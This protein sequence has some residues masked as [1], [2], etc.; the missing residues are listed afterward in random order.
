M[1][2]PKGCCYPDCFV[3]PLDDCYYDDDELRITEIE[4]L[5][6]LLANLKASKKKGERLKDNPLYRKA[7]NRRDY[8]LNYEE[9]IDYQNRYRTR[10]NHEEG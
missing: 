1:S 8:L 9:R 3:C 2:K 10:K 4:E 7:F 5:N 6:V